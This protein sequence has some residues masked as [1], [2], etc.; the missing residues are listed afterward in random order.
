[1]SK[2]RKVAIKI[3]FGISALLIS[4]YIPCTI[5]IVDFEADLKGFATALFALFLLVPAGVFG[6][7]GSYLLSG[8]KFKLSRKAI[9][10]RIFNRYFGRILHGH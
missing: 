7:L 1:M 5:W 4:V 10:R 8:G 6:F 2:T 9:D 3:L